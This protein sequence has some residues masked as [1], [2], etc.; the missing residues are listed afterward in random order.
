MNSYVNFSDQQLVRLLKTD[1]RQAFRVLYDRYLRKLYYFILRT[2]K[3]P[4]LTEDVV[5]DVF[6]R[7]WEGRSHIDPEQSF[8]AYL[9]TVARYR[10]LNLLKRSQHESAIL[11]EMMKYA[12]PPENTTDLRIAFKESN[13]LFTKAVDQLPGKCREVF[14]RCKIEGLSYKQVAEELGI[15]EGTVNSQMVKAL[16]VIRRYMGL[17]DV[18]GLILI[19]F[20]GKNG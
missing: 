3:S 16:K 12:L 13:G 18:A 15:T 19:L 7:I 5:Q 20:A 17:K 4:D 14:I 10:L 11:N 1:D 8:K 9:Y 2:A 6:I